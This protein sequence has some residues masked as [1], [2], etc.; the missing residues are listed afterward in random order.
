MLN[1]A[2]EKDFLRNFRII[3]LIWFFGLQFLRDCGSISIVVLLT[4]KLSNLQDHVL[5][6]DDRGTNVQLLP[7]STKGM[8]WFGLY[9]Q[10]R[11]HWSVKNTKEVDSSK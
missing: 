9:F 10:N 1:L 8:S 6:S 11:T 3:S 7:Y 2:L 5:G 4:I